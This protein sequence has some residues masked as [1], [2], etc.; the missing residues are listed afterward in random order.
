MRNKEI[1]N[2]ALSQVREER[3]GKGREIIIETENSKREWLLQEDKTNGY[4]RQ[5]ELYSQDPNKVYNF[6]RGIVNSHILLKGKCW[7]QEDPAEV[8]LPIITSEI[9][10]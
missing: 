6:L 2:S 3:E 1:F 5:K 8:G 4:F 9:I 7:E 10:K